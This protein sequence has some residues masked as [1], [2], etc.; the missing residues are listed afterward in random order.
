MLIAREPGFSPTLSKTSLVFP[1]RG[2]VV[3]VMGHHMAVEGG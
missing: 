1:L 2:L 3:W